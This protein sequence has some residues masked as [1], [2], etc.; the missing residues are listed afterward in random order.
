MVLPTIEGSDPNRRC[1]MPL[2]STATLPPRGRS[3]SGVNV[4]PI[5]RLRAK[6]PEELL[7]DVNAFDL[8]RTVAAA[9]VQSGAA[10]VVGGDILQHLCLRA[11][12]VVFRHGGGGAASLRRAIH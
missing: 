8:L 1:Q 11:P 4:R 7:R 9:E 10:G 5:D 12:D 6:E 2:D 3:S